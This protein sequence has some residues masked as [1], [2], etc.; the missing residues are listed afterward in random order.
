VGEFLAMMGTYKVSTWGAIFATTGIILGAGYMLWLYWRIAYGTARTGEAAA[1]TDLDRREWLLL[2]PIAAIVLWMGIYPESFMAPMRDDVGRLLARIERVTPAGDSRP[3]AGNP[4]AAA[5][6]ATE[7][8]G[9]E[10][11]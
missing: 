2:A 6:K 7:H 9:G 3:T 4:A 1:M 8:G 10:A 11:H 5:A